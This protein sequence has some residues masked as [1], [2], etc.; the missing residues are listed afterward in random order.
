MGSRVNAA[1]VDRFDRFFD[2]HF[3]AMVALARRQRVVASVVLGVG[4]LV[5]IGAELFVVHR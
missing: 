4:T 2:G 1:Q 3:E 5:A